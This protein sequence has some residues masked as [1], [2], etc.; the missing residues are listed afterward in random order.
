MDGAAT[1]IWLAERG[2]EVAPSEDAR[3]ALV[4]WAAAHDVRLEPAHDPPPAAV[5]WDAV[6][7][8]EKRLLEVR[9]AL[10][11]LDFDAA[12]RSLARAGAILRE[13]PELPNAAW[14]RAEVD[15]AWSARWLREHDEERARSAWQ[16]AAALD[17]GRAAGLGERAFDLPPVVHIALRLEGESEGSALRLDGSAVSPGDVTRA[18]GEHAL[19][20]LEPDGSVVWAAWITFAEGSVIRVA[21]PAAPA[22]ST[23]DMKQARLTPDGVRGHVRC[24]AWIAA[25]AGETGVVRVATCGAETCA[26]LVEWRSGAARREPSAMRSTPTPDAA[27]RHP[28]PRWATW[29]LAAVGV[30]G[31]ALGVAAAAGAFRSGGATETQF[32]N[33]GLQIH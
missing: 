20:I 21:S 10:D 2:A 33:G 16:R 15:R 13:H 17:G 4:S 32:V 29:T 7:V 5:D 11:G 24:G 8:V 3:A 28:W 18:A 6:A 30:A 9:E 26:P 23:R 31:T 27:R 19:A 14:L 22:C 12:E 25:V 1:V